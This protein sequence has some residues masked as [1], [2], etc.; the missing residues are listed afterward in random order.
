MITLPADA[1]AE[2]YITGN[3]A[4]IR[5]LRVAMEGA[6][7]ASDQG[8]VVSNTSTVR[9][10]V[11]IGSGAI[12]D[13]TGLRAVSSIV[14]D[15]TVNLT[16]GPSNLAVLGRAETSSPTAPGTA[17]PATCCHRRRADSTRC[18]GSRSAA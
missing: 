3:N 5:N 15:A 13:A 14:F 1:A 11:V 4:T 6:D 2:P 18:P 10:V 17:R 12:T 8:I 9:N 16:Q 7:S